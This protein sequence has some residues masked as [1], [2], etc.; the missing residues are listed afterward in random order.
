MKFKYRIRLTQQLTLCNCFSTRM[1]HLETCGE[2][3]FH[4]S[5]DD[6]AKTFIDDIIQLNVILSL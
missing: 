4:E 2:E 5:Q 6:I 3:I 1:T